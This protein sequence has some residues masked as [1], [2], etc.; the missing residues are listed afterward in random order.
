M[1]PT[2]DHAL[3]AAAWLAVAIMALFNHRRERRV[4]GQIQWHL[5]SAIIFAVMVALQ[6]FLALGG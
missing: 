4:P 5:I 6:V 3:Q 2:T 1:S